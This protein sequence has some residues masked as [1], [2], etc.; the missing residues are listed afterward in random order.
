MQKISTVKSWRISFLPSCIILFYNTLVAPPNNYTGKLDSFEKPT[1]LLI[2]QGEHVT[3]Q[4][5]FIQ[6]AQNLLIPTDS[7]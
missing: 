1:S 6:Y 2:R 5:S 7:T 3:E 4:V